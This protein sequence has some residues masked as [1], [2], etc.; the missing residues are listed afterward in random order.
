M[1]LLVIKSRWPVKPTGLSSSHSPPRIQSLTHST[2]STWMS[3]LRRRRRRSFAFP[4]SG[5]AARPRNRY[6]SPEIGVHSYVTS[7]SKQDATGLHQVTG[8]VEVVE[9]KGD[10]PL[11]RHGPIR[12]AARPSA[13][14][15]R[16]R[17]AVLLAGR[18][19]VDGPLRPTPLAGR[20]SKRWPPT[21]RPRALRSSRSWPGFTP[22][23]R[24]SIRA[25]PTR[26]VSPGLGNS[27]IRPEYFD[28]PTAVRLS[29]GPGLAPCVVMA[30][31]LSC[32][33]WASRR[34]RRTCVM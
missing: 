32:P 8:K 19:L 25:A 34:C 31:G 7:C 18:H 13:P 22:T 28:G 30:L 11:Y 12:V 9:C 15:T 6:T 4:H 3:P 14:R 26:P 5:P 21:A 20:D 33:G 2:R 24:P 29:G 17:H 27:R 23:C 10:N 1:L 16:R